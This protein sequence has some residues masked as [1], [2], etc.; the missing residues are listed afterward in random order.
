[1]V[2]VPFRTYLDLAGIPNGDIGL[3]HRTLSSR[4][5]DDTNPTVT[6]TREWEDS[7]LALKCDVI[8][9]HAMSPQAAFTRDEHCSRCSNPVIVRYRG[10]MTATLSPSTET[11]LCPWCGHNWTL[12]IP[13]PLLWVEKRI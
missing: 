13:G 12:E 4:V 3:A 2:S 11:I 9:S 1:M 5:L 10:N 7:A 6:L 8:R